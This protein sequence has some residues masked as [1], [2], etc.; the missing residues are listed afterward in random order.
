VVAGLAAFVRVADT[1]AFAVVA[2]GSDT[3]VAHAQAA[4]VAAV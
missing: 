1:S 4:E 2:E 3:V